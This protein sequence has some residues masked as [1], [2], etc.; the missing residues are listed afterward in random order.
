MKP[1]DYFYDNPLNTGRGTPWIFDHIFAGLLRVLLTPAFRLKTRGAEHIRELDE[2]LILAGNHRSYLDPLFPL[3]AMRPRTVRFI[4]KEEFFKIRGVR[5]LASW[6]G[7]YPVKR[8]A[9]D[10]KVVKR[11]VAMLKRG[12]L[13]GIFPEGTRG[14]GE[15]LVEGERDAREGVALIANLARARVVPFR[16]W[17]TEKISPEG[18]RRWHF[19]TVKLSF[20]EPLSLADPAYADLEKAE[21]LRRF[22]HDIMAAIYALP[23]PEQ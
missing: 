9:A 20:G 12:E 6:V 23:E 3:M 13:V 5:R 18:S 10:L 8:A 1:L 7:V 16:L 19:P 15:E 21:K 4:G 17:N 11:S 2:G 14:R 22:T